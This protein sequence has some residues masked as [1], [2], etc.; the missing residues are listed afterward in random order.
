MVFSKSS[1]SLRRHTPLLFKKIDWLKVAKKTGGL[2][3]TLGTGL[4]IGAA[5]E[6]IADKLFAAVKQDPSTLTVDTIKSLVE[7][8]A[9]V[10]KEGEEVGNT[11][12]QIH[13]F[14]EEF[15]KFIKM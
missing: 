3:L 6:A 9:G 5:A 14:R 8:G 10:L 2:L 1:T 12:R 11:A 4:P 15:E 7:G 13:E